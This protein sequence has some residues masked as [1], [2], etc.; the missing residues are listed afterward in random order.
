[1]DVIGIG[2]VLVSR[3]LPDGDIAYAG[4]LVD[5]WCLGVKDALLRVCSEARYED[6]AEHLLIEE[7]LEEVEPAYAK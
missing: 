3:R 5:P 2:T 4:F 7:S 6:F 1:M